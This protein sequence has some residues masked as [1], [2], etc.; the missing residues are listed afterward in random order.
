MQLQ[1]KQFE[2]K[3]IQAPNFVMSP[4]ELK[5]YIDFEVKRV[6][7]ISHPTGNTGQ[8]CHLKE[9]ELFVMVSGSCTAVIDKGQGLEDIPLNSPQSALYIGNYVWHGF[10]DFSKD[11]VLLAVSSTNYNPNREDYIEDY[12]KYKQKLKELGV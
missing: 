9:Q 12:E 4:L 10:K 6:Y 11:A 3:K 7:F 2:V 8:H 1:F 5:E